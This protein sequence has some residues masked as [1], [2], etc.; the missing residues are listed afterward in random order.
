VF[1]RCQPLCARHTPLRDE[2]FKPANPLDSAPCKP[3]RHRDAH[4]SFRIRS[5]A[6]HRGGG[7]CFSQMSNGHASDRGPVPRLRSFVCH[8]YENCRG[9][10]NDFHFGTRLPQV[11]SHRSLVAPLV[12]NHFQLSNSSNPFI[13]T[14]IHQC[15]GG[16]PPLRQLSS[17]HPYFIASMLLL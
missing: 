16:I 12:F 9:A 1:C 13:F 6:K 8:S 15:P 5:Y 3:S 14:F 2:K 10:Q 7:Y 17:L 11:N 4:K